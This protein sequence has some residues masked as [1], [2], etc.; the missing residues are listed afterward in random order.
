[1]ALLAAY[2]FDEAADAAIE[3]VTGNG[4]GFALQTGMS[5]EAGHTG[6]AIV[7]TNGD[8]TGPA[9]FGQTAQRTVM[10]W[11]KS[12]A[13]FNGWIFEWHST[14]GDSGRWGL[15]CLNGQMGFRGTPV[16]GSAL[17]A[18][19]ARPSDGAW[20]HWAGTFDG[21][22]V[23]LYVDGVLRAT[24]GTLSGGIRTDAD[25]IKWHT[26][27]SGAQSVDDLR[28]YDEAL[29]LATINAL[30]GTP[31]TADTEPD[32]EEHSGTLDLSGSGSLLYISTPAVAADLSAS[33]TGTLDP[34]GRPSFGGAV[35]FAGSSAL[36]TETAPA[37][38]GSLSLAGSGAQSRA[39][40]PAASAPL[41]L[42]G[43]G[44]LDLTASGAGGGTLAL[45]GLGAL[46]LSGR[47]ALSA[48]LPLSGSGALSLAGRPA[49]SGAVSLSGSGALTL[50]DANAEP[51]DLSLTAS[52]EAPRFTAAL[53]QS[54]FDATT[55]AT[56]PRLSAA[57]ERAHLSGV[58]E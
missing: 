14:S 7:S 25:V 53:E 51:R 44:A 41:A 2:N 17:H 47:V 56:R 30:M 50:D 39:G 31:V 23:R 5:R 24:T 46:A 43:A 16:S 42:S 6:S 1:M 32:P 11:L 13:S 33:G 12:G 58:L 57:L 15:L 10:F 55:A 37:V 9:M 27:V 21:S 36:E 19:I 34:S 3:D 29:D 48:A 4:H 38:P 45:A 52:L 26:T 18:A 8:V 54:R 49:A 35:S 40:S 20:H 28:V 22:V